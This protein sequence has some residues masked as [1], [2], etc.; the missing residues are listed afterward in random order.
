[1]QSKGVQDLINQAQNIDG[2]DDTSLLKG[3]SEAIK[4]QFTKHNADY[5]LR[6]LQ[7]LYS[8]K[9]VDNRTVNNI[10]INTTDILEQA[11]E[12]VNTALIKKTLEVRDNQVIKILS[13]TA[14]STT[15]LP[16]SRRG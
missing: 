7:L 12:L 10:Q 16:Y 5:A 14:K 6:W 3:I 13:T 15:R 1:M 2:L 9:N 8:N 4:H 11:I